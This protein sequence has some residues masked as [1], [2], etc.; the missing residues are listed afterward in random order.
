MTIKIKKISSDAKLPQ[1]ANEHDAGMDFFS[2]EECIIK[3][4]ERKLLSTGISMAIPQGQVGLICDK[5]GLAVKHGLKTMAGVV[6][7]GYRGEIKIVVHNL[8]DKDYLV[9]K[10]NKIAQ[11]LIQRIEQKE[12]LEVE[13]L[14]ETQR[15][16]GGF[17]SS[18]LK[19]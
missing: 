5:S 12:L 19:F 4:G 2:N 18:G 14:D 3:P 9:E 1:Y 8:S 17:G 6:D 13:E 15:G 10:G 7:S 16:E 11:M